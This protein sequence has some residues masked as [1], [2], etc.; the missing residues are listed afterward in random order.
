MGARN[1]LSSAYVCP[2]CH[3]ALTCAALKDDLECVVC[4]N[5]HTFP[6]VG[7]LARFVESDGYAASFGLQWQIHARDQLDSATGVSLSRDRLF[8]GTGWPHR[9]Q[10]ESILEA[11][12]GS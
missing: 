11:G 12:C 5:G 10:G 8:R 4:S 9:M 2:K 1:D 6:V 3:A 7:G